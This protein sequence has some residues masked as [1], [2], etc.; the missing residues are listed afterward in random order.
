MKVGAIEKGASLEVLLFIPLREAALEVNACIRKDYEDYVV[1]IR[2]VRTGWENDQDI[3]TCTL[4]T[5]RVGLFW[6]WFELET[7][8]GYGMKFS[9]AAGGRVSF[10]GRH[11]EMRPLQ[12]TVYE[13]KYAQPEWLKGGIIYQVF[14]DRFARGNDPRVTDPLTHPDG[15]APDDAPEA[16]KEAGGEMSSEAFRQMEEVL[17]A[18]PV[19]SRY[20]I[21][22]YDE[23]Y[24]NRAERSVVLRD[25]W[26]ACPHWAPDQH[27]EILNNDFFGG[28]LYGIREKIPYLKS[29]GVTCLYLNPIFESYSNHRYDTGDYGKVDAL[30]GDEEAFRAL[31]A[32]CEKAGIRV[33]LD[34]VFNHTGD[35]SL[36]FNRYGTY[37]SY[38]AWNHED[39]PYR[40]RYNWTGYYDYHTWWGIRT[41]P[42]VRKDSYAH[43]EMLFSGDGIIRR[44]I[45]AGA[46]GWRLDVVDELPTPF[47]RELVS[48]A[49]AE[50]SDAVVL[51]EVWEDASN[52]IAYESRR[53]YFQG[54]ELDSV[55]N[56]PWKD[57]IL[58][59]LR[60]SNGAGLGD[61][62]TEICTNYP[63]EV[64]SCLMNPLGTHDSV[65]AITALAGEELNTNDRSL[66]YQTRL[67]EAEYAHGRML[68]KM[69]VLI[70][71]FLPGVPSIYY[72]DE[73]GMEGYNDPFNRRCYPWGEEDEELLTW[74]RT[75]TALR[76]ERREFFG[77]AD[78]EVLHADDGVFAFR[79]TNA[80]RSV[81][82]IVNRS[83]D[84]YATMCTKGYVMIESDYAGMAK[85]YRGRVEKSGIA[86]LVTV[87][88]D[89]GF[90][91]LEGLRSDK[92]DLMYED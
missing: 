75:V 1:R 62:V 92:I 7:G 41:L 77:E 11:E 10:V 35:D 49:K 70:Q 40:E 57:A 56:Y 44:W 59:Y 8:S 76:S 66:K 78:C 63:P 19:K 3:Y 6:Y 16:E 39:S 54:E 90:L 68:M 52:K 48:A 84:S 47:L 28:N 33:I 51:G 23:W 91:L 34:G 5:D 9:C 21:R 14:I 58:S 43:R 4:P 82:C 60:D 72:G 83:S 45:R 37:D 17:K 25:E 20:H 69:A 50:R 15:E 53:S 64:L 74:Y 86:K 79:R 32:D 27:G 36:Y 24:D 13:R 42:T 80:D 26:G 18:D 31:C 12:L 73:A 30:I 29:L 85:K 81:V 22:S 65:R 87:P 2:M 46:A 55:M 88:A 61:S 38:G 89:Y 67:S 71:M